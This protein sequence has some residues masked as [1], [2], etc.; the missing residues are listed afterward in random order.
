MGIMQ[1]LQ[2]YTFTVVSALSTLTL[3][4]QV[5]AALLLIVLLK[6]IFTHSES[7][8]SRWVSRNGLLLM[9]I[10]A[11][12]AMS[13]SLFFSEIAQ[14]VPCKDCWLQRICMYPQVLL[15]IIALWKRD[16]TVARYILALCVIGMVISVS[17]YMEQVQAALHPIASPTSGVN[18]LIKPCDASGVSCAA[19]QINFAYGYITIPMMALSAF[20]LNAIGS[21]MML[22]SK[23]AI[24]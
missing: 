13:G 17:H 5:I 16:R 11:L 19:T 14:W 23:K 12:T 24:A 20:L 2:S 3:V 6:D 8:L 18:A 10:V 15:L 22:R 21:V 1:F 4:A 9:F 7:K